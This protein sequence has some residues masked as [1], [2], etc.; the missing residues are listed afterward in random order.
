[1]SYELCYVEILHHLQVQRDIKTLQISH[2]I[3]KYNCCMHN[4][5][6]Q[7]QRFCGIFECSIYGC[8]IYGW[9]TVFPLSDHSE[10]S[11]SRIKPYR[12]CISKI[13][14]RIPLFFSSVESTV[15]LAEFRA[16][17]FLGQ[18]SSDHKP[19]SDKLLKFIIWEYLEIFKKCVEEVLHDM[20]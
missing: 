18:C 13:H 11:P 20:V 2:P 17:T 1:M 10:F 5:E 8:C 9:K 16:L 15:P 3:I 19:S 14:L 7:Q 6:F 4:F 12:I